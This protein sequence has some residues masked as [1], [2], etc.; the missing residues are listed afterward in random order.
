M[1]RTLQ[2]SMNAQKPKLKKIFTYY[3]FSK[4]NGNGEETTIPEASEDVPESSAEHSIVQNLR[5][6][7]IRYEE[8]KIEA[9]LGCGIQEWCKIR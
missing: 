6:I 1:V 7:A 9:D 8:N 2:N 4:N 3:L 5:N